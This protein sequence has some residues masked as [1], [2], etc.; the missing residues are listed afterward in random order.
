MAQLGDLVLA[1]M[2]QEQTER[3]L[4]PF[5]TPAKPL[6]PKVLEEIKKETPV[7]VPVAK[8]TPSVKVAQVARAAQV[9]KTPVPTAAQQIPIAIIQPIPVVVAQPIPVLTPVDIAIEIEEALPALEQDV[10]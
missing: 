10:I 9:N 4:R 2:S 6:Q 8:A 3:H 1:G 7:L 5:L